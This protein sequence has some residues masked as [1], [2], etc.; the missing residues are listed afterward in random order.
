MAMLD[1]EP[2]ATPG[3]LDGVWRQLDYWATVYQRTWKSGI[4]GSFLSPLFYVVAMGVVLGGFVKTDPARLEGATSYLEFF[5]P[6]VV[7]AFAMQTAAFEATYP[8]MSMI[9]WQKVYDSMLASPLAVSQVVAA[10]LLFVVFRIA[11]TCGVFMLV[12]VPFGVFHSWWGP[13]LAYLAQILVGTVFAVWVYGL[14][15]RI[16]SEES[17]GVIFRLGVFPLFLFSG[18]F[19]PISNLGHVGAW[20]ARLTPLWH[21]VNLSR[22]LCLDHV[23]WSTAAINL[24]VLLTLLALGWPW[25][26][27]GLTRRLVS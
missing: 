2:R 1:R 12:L 13:I 18:A 24:A 6:G 16:R 22:M 4:A 23:D 20:V 26:V 3:F 5:V 9:K 21:G 17:F 11:T 8:V 10:H 25:A 19:F 15:T 27:R 14:T 7:A